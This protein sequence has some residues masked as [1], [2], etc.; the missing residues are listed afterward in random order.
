MNFVG[1]ESLLAY[2]RDDNTLTTNEKKVLSFL[3]GRIS[4][5]KFGELAGIEKLCGIIIA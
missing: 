1:D 3:K 2:R 5:Q 4:L